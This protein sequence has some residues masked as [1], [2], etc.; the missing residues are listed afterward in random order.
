MS[1]KKCDFFKNL[2][3]LEVSELPLYEDDLSHDQCG[4][5]NQCHFRMHR[6]VTFVLLV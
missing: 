4:Q 1:V 2:V 6:L 3:R 5:E